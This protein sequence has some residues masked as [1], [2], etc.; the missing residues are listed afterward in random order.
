MSK[1][2]R[3][4]LGVAFAALAL[5][6]ASQGGD[7]APLRVGTSGDYAPFSE[8]IEGTGAYRGFDI[9]VAEAFARDRGSEIEWV[10]FRWVDLSRDFAEGRFDLVMSG[11]TV[12][13]DRSVLGRFSVPVVAS[14][15]VLLFDR[16]RFDSTGPA[17]FDREGM[18][19]AVNRGGHLERVARAHFR[20]ARVET[21]A[22]NED[23]RAALANREVDAI[24]TDTLEAPRWLVGLQNVGRHGPLTR[25]RK[26]YWVAPDRSALARELDRWLMAREADGSLA[27][28]R[29]RWFG[30]AG[31]VVDASPASSLVAAIAERLALM[32]WVAESKRVAGRAVE[33]LAREAR[34]LDAAS[35]AIAREA[36]RQSVAPPEDE[37]VRA[38]Y[39]AQIEAAKAIQYA[40]LAV[41]PIRRARAEDLADVLRPALIRIGDRMASLIVT[42][43]AGRGHI[44]ESDVEQLRSTLVDHALPSERVDAVLEAFR[45]L[46]SGVVE[47]QHHDRASL[48]AAAQGREEVGHGHLPAVLAM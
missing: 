43:R 44:S 21:R 39:R 13:A 33:D 12:R 36:S 7:R 20:N 16:S 30:E 45:A 41:P 3:L 23:V 32:S 24:V 38:F 31:S 10:P 48:D 9:E 37:V 8:R 17:S 22:A 15:A 2:L 4:Y 11:V 40:T 47:A 25:D 34:V 35:S 6:C 27:A 18:R 29:E 42:L 19:I 1:R 46:G 14:G 26:A 28:L 5:G